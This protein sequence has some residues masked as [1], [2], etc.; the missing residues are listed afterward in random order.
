MDRCPRTAI[1]R[2]RLALAALAALLVLAACRREAPPTERPPEP[3]AT[4]T[5][6]APGG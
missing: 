6:E 5:A 2:A 3:Q 1:P 4:A